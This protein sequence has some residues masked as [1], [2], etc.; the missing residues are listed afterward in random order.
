MYGGVYVFL[1]ECNIQNL[2]TEALIAHAYGCAFEQWLNTFPQAEQQA[3]LE[4]MVDD[5]A[6]YDS[7]VS[8]IMHAKEVY[9]QVKILQTAQGVLHIVDVRSDNEYVHHERTVWGMEHYQLGRADTSCSSQHTYILKAGT[10]DPN[11]EC[12]HNYI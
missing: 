9:V 3:M 10:L 12:N 7:V 2:R 4:K 1:R 8:M 5:S 11:K 6:Y